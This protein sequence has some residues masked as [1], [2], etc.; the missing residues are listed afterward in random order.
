MMRIFQTATGQLEV[1]TEG[2]VCHVRFDLPK[3]AISKEDTSNGAR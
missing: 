1:K 3:P 2:N